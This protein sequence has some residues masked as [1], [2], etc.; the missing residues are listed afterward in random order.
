MSQSESPFHPGERQVQARLGVRDIEDWARKV[1]RPYLPEQH[2]AFHTALPFLVA[3]ARDAR[4]RPWV[5]LLT[6]PDGFVT[7]P[8]PRTLMIGAQPVLGDA[9]EGSLGAGADVGILGIEPAT[10]RRNRVNGRVAGNAAGAIVFAVGQSFGNCP[11]HITERSWH[12]A[13]AAP[14]ADARHGNRLRKSARRQIEEAD[15]FFIATGHR[16]RGEH[17]SFGMDVSHRGGPRGFVEIEDDATLLVP[18]YAGNNHF[19]TL[20]NLELDPR[21]G[22]LFV[23]FASG[24]VL[25]LSGRAEVVWDPAV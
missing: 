9:L 18:D 22:L 16:A 11:Q 23:D 25:Q 10:R 3:A 12:L 6:G 7:S 20:G 21:A 8:D 5:T 17:E 14:L 2:R 4:G 19:N 24:G 1:V 15:T 13:Q